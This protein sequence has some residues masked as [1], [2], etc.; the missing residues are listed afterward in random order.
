MMLAAFVIVVGFRIYEE[1]FQSKWLPLWPFIISKYEALGTRH[2]AMASMMASWTRR[3]SVTQQGFAPKAFVVCSR[4][5]GVVNF[6]ADQAV[7]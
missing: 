7:T 5:A 6:S 3:S 4:P 1:M 2:S